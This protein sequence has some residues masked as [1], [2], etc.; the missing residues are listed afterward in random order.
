MSFTSRSTTLA[1][2]HLA[3]SPCVPG[4]DLAAQVFDGAEHLLRAGLLRLR[5]RHIWVG[6]EQL[7]THT[8]CKHAFDDKPALWRSAAAP[9]TVESQPL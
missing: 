2:A 5:L 4:F 7:V 3:L 6:F 1:R 9:S 8:A